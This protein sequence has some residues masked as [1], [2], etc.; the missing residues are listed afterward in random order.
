ML[1]PIRIDS[2]TEQLDSIEI[3]A[4]CLYDIHTVNG[5]RMYAGANNPS[6]LA[7]VSKYSLWLCHSAT[8][9]LVTLA[10]EAAT[11]IM[12][13]NHHCI[14]CSSVLGSTVRLA[15]LAFSVEIPLLVSIP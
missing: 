6:R 15:A 9:V 3:S 13:M 2:G 5:A 11:V 12:G 1:N 7:L 4:L 14:M 10:S 8:L